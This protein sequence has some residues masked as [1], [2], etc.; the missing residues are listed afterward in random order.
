M[1]AATAGAKAVVD[2]VVAAP[3]EV[4]YELVSDVTKMGRWSPETTS[5]RW[6]RPATGPAVGARFRGA[7]R[8]GWR[9]WST[10]CT[11]VSAQP[12]H[13]FAFEVTLGPL[14][15]SRWSYDIASEG[16]GSRLTETWTD[17]RPMW[18]VRISPVVMGVRDRAGHNREG[19]QATLANL[20]RAA[21]E[22]PSP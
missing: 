15:I 10:T 4:L 3:A 11:V 20:A 13:Q 19:M 6:L 8:Q 21:E 18:M 12:G 16:D 7:N 1:E 17:M 9:R 14:P 2:K 5:C 22:V